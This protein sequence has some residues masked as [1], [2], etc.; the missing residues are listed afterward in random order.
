MLQAAEA[1]DRLLAAIDPKTLDT[2]ARGVDDVIG[3]LDGDKV[4]RVPEIGADNMASAGTVDRDERMVIGSL[5]AVCRRPALG[6]DQFVTGAKHAIGTG[7][8]ADHIEPMG[9]DWTERIEIAARHAAIEP[10]TG[11]IGDEQSLAIARKAGE[12]GAGFADAFEPIAWRDLRLGSGT[13]CQKQKG[14]EGRHL[15]ERTHRK[16]PLAENRKLGS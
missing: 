6:D 13:C 7:R 8:I 10:A 5:I 2:V 14:D 9:K 15:P 1:H 11:E 3:I 16:P 12:G 4:E